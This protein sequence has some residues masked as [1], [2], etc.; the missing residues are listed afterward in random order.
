VESFGARIRLCR[1]LG[2]AAVTCA[3]SGALA[4]SAFGADAFTPASGS[5]VTVGSNPLSVASSPDGKTVAVV[6]GNDHSLS[7]FSASPDGKLTPLIG[8]P[9]QTGAG[10]QAVAFSPD[11]ATIAVAN[12]SAS[13]VSTYVVNSGHVVPTGATDSTA[14]PGGHGSDP[15]SVAFS[16]DGSLIATADLG[17]YISVLR[18]GS[19]SLVSGYPV[20]ADPNIV[21]LAWGPDGTIAA[22]DGTSDQ[23][24]LYAV[25]QPGDVLLPLSI[26][27]LHTGAG[28]NP[29]K[30]AFSRNGGFLAAADRDSGQISEWSLPTG[31]PVAGSPFQEP[32]GY[33]PVAVSYS[34]G[35]DLL[36]VGNTNGKVPVLKVG[37]NG[38]LAPVA[39]SPYTV[40][41][42]SGA[43]PS[44]AFGR[45]GGLLAAVDEFNDQLAMLTV[46]PPTI[47]VT[48]PEANAVYEQH[49]DAPASFSCTD[50]VAGP[51]ITSCTATHT[52][53]AFLDTASVG[54]VP[55]EITATS[56]DG[57]VTT[58][59]ASYFVAPLELVMHITPSQA[60]TSSSPAPVNAT[61]TIKG[62]TAGVTSPDYVLELPTGLA[63][64]Q[65][66][67]T[68]CPARDANAAAL[69][70]SCDNSIVATGQM[71]LDVS[72]NPVTQCK[73][74][75]ELVDVAKS[76]NLTMRV[77]PPSA[78]TAH[79]PTAPAT[80]EVKAGTVL[81]GGAH[82]ELLFTLP[83]VLSGPA[84]GTRFAFDRTPSEISLVFGVTG[85]KTHPISFL[86]SVGCPAQPARSLA[87]PAPWTATVSNSGNTATA[88]ASCLPFAPPRHHNPTKGSLKLG[89]KAQLTV[90]GT[91]VHTIA[92]AHSYVIADKQGKLYT[93]HGPGT[94]PAPGTTLLV[95]LRK[96]RDAQYLQTCVTTE[97]PA[98]DSAVLR[99]LVTA[100]VPRKH[101]FV[102]S[103]PGTSILLKW[104]GIQPVLARLRGLKGAPGNS[105]PLGH[106]I[107]VDA[108][109]RN[110]ELIVRA[111]KV[112]PVFKGSMAIVGVLTQI[113]KGGRNGN[114]NAQISLTD[115][116]TLKQNWNL[117]AKQYD[118][119]SV[120][121]GTTKL[122]SEVEVMGKY[123]PGSG[124]NVLGGGVFQLQDFSFG[125]QQ[126][127]TSGSKPQKLSGPG[128]TLDQW[129]NAFSVAAGLA[130]VSGSP[131]K[132]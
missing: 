74:A 117:S 10:P 104:S 42:S 73:L 17:G 41:A 99:G 55:M 39:G 107:R 62:G 81:G 15:V 106:L 112:G 121:N 57:Q 132:G 87:P 22:A 61:L 33:A 88:T 83:S 119:S 25:T 40:S 23:V 11:D 80:A 30:V 3:V 84:D 71:T 2:A 91:V 95:G 92:L 45:S 16:P 56:A 103:A 28:S 4:G 102:L 89:P 7:V 44:V 13:T 101:E 65:A 8:S 50:A 85:T 120:G 75:L 130:C 32:P 116:G 129:Q 34:P 24:S 64:Q 110:A 1:L 76:P 113:T 118:A 123:H 97:S 69:P 49:S 67:Y 35:S 36:A 86:S 79:C 128:I 5:P 126:T 124:V 18:N 21:S 58:Q 122:D 70:A 94:L 19:L 9:V 12:A 90:Q 37:P 46:G 31:A 59:P 43:I 38:G 63:A 20:A 93:V 131:S 125:V 115:D 66:G 27:P 68:G 82:L 114:T 29:R 47:T 6:N 26:S 48:S 72:S 54:Q 108:R 98:E 14:V 77:E 109:I 51:G 100:V 96:L 53:G 60:G 105:T 127:S 78:Q 111:A 52:N